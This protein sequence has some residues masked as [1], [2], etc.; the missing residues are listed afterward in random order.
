M[1][2]EEQKELV[3]LDCDK[4]N[5]VIIEAYAGAGKTSTLLEFCKKR[6]SKNILYLVY[7]ASMKKEAEIKFK[8]LENVKIFTMHGL[9]Y[10]SSNKKLLEKLGDV[11]Q[12]TLLEITQ[13]N[14]I[15]LDIFSSHTILENIKDFL[16]SDYTNFKDFLNSQ[17]KPEISKTLKIYNLLI[18]ENNNYPITHDIYLKIFQIKTPVLEND[19]IL[20]DEAQDLNDCVVDIIL[21]Q[22][23]TKIF[24]G[25]SFQSIYGFRGANNVLKRIADKKDVNEIKTIYLTNS[26]RCSPSVAILANRYLQILGAKKDFKGLNNKNSE[27]ISKAYLSR[28]NLNLL[29]NA[30]NNSHKKLYFVGGLNS[31]NIQ[32]LED[33]CFLFSKNETIKER[34]KNPFLKSFSGAKEFLKNIS[35]TENVE[36]KSKT[37]SFLFFVNNKISIFDIKK[38]LKDASNGVKMKDADMIFSTAHKSKGLE[39]DEVTLSDDFLDLSKLKKDN[40][41]LYNEELRLLYVAITR[42]KYKIN[43]SEKNYLDNEKIKEI[44]C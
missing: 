19:I 32:D 3:E 5:I 43:I 16:I 30:Y 12:Q 21:K 38:K 24:I 25:D 15:S 17:N 1:L 28:T 39:F 6:P 14:N 20:I 23:A 34:I 36:W 26:F 13:E 22:K 9:A 44:L 29:K 37:T 2:T 40:I 18:D 4:N 11:T 8:D 42:A 7:N 35:E 41:T 33:L 31:Y 10:K 27:S